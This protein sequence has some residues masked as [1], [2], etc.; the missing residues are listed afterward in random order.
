MPDRVAKRLAEYI[1]IYK[2]GP[3]DS[4]FPLCVWYICGLL[5][6]MYS[7][8]L[9]EK[10]EFLPQP[11]NFMFNGF[12]FFPEFCRTGFFQKTSEHDCYAGKGRCHEEAG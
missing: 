1:A 11:I 7:A 5:R 10:S 12:L 6:V 2:F 8:G 9:N 3:V 4:L